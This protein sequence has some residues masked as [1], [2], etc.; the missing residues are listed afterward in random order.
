MIVSLSIVLNSL[1]AMLTEHRRLVLN[2]IIWPKLF[3][4]IINQ[5]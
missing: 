3:R 5:P 1:S 4:L 2:H